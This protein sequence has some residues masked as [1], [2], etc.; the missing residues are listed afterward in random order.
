[1]ASQ[2]GPLS[3]LGIT[4]SYLTQLAT[5]TAQNGTIQGLGQVWQGSGKSFLGSAGQ[6]LAGSLAGSAVNVALNSVLGTQVAGPQG[7][8]LD[9]GANLLASTITPYVTSSVAAGIN[10]SI[11]NSLKSAGPFG[12]VLSQLGTGLVN[13]VLGSAT[14]S[15]FGAAVQGSNYKSFPGGGSEPPADYGGSS[16]TLGLSGG[17]VVFS[18]QP[19]NQGPQASGLDQASVFPKTITQLPADTFTSMP[20][21]APNAT[22]NAIK[23]GAMNNAVGKK[24]FSS[25]LSRNFTNLVV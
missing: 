6:S 7:L 21:L 11:N 8:K 15:I 4:P 25:D 20:P 5:T 22:A 16:Y 18:I 2:G 13:Q 12:P 24:A 23:Q 14:N 19:A 3:L 9:S 17:D 1:M 10:Q